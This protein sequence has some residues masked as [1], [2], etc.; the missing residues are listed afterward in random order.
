MGSYLIK[1]ILISALVLNA[2]HKDYSLQ[3]GLVDK[4]RYRGDVRKG[5]FR[6]DKRQ[7]H[8]KPYL[9]H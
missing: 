4:C 2:S 5:A 6:N 8:Y 9:Q 1:V 3:E 7:G